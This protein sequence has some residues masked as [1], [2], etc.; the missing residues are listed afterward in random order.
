MPIFEIRLAVKE[1]LLATFHQTRVLTS[2]KYVA[3]L[4]M[5][6]PKSSKKYRLNLNGKSVLTPAS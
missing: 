4:G 2:R 3:V 1:P 6:I 5:N